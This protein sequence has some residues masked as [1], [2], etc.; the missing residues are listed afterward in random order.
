VNP[1]PA[2][3]ASL[4][5]AAGTPETI[6]QDAGDYERIAIDLGRATKKVAAIKAKL[7]AA[8]ATAP[9]FDPQAWSRDV[10]S[11]YESMWTAYT[12]GSS[13]A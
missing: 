4:C 13:A 10:E 1:G 12:K 3:G 11:A 7:A 9:L 6:A 2:W 5:Q 8:R